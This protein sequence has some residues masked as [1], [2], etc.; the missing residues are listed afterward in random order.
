MSYY[1]CSSIVLNYDRRGWIRDLG[2]YPLNG[3]AGTSH[4]R[5]TDH[6]WTDC[7]PTLPKYPNLWQDDLGNITVALGYDFVFDIGTYDTIQQGCGT[8]VSFYL[9]PLV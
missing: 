7:W 1:P 4:R 9:G 8:D 2:Q 6:L 5:Y 3:N